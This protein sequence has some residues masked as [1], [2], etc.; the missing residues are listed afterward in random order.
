MASA[1]SDR[2]VASRDTKVR[3]KKAAVVKAA[4]KA[5]KAAAKAPAKAAVKAPAKPA[6]AVPTPTKRPSPNSTPRSPA[7]A[8]ASVSAPKATSAPK[9]ASGGG[10]FATNP[11]SKA[12]LSDYKQKESRYNADSAKKPAA[13]AASASKPKFSL[14][15]AMK[16]DTKKYVKKGK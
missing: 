12:G 8:K 14:L 5:P 9:A 10:G 4:V 13:P 15:N 16:L 1:N 3:K 6:K 2:D 11:R 7:P